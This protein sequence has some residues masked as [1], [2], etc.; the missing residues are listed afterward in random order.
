MGHRDLVQE[1][2]VISYPSDDPTRVQRLPQ[3]VRKE[4][5]RYQDY[6]QR[7]ARVEAVPGRITEEGRASFSMLPKD[8][9]GGWRAQAKE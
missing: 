3:C 9:V 6:R 1:H 5:Q 2:G 8:A 7:E 4:I